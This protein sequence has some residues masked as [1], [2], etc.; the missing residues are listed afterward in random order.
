[1]ES[2]FIAKLHYA[3]E[4]QTQLFFVTEYVEGGELL[5]L[6]TYKRAFTE[7]W[8]QFYSAE[9]VLALECLHERDIIYRDL[10][11]SN[12]MI[13]KDGHAKLIDFGLGRFM[14]VSKTQSFCGAASYVAPEVILNQDYTRAV[15]WWSLVLR[16]L[17]VGCGNIR[18]VGRTT[19]ILGN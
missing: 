10:K 7:D 4:N 13:D 19:T 11:T 15:G 1:M 3:F 16:T 6:L 2:K 18:D 17:V 5:E 9:L 12:I 14:V 8:T